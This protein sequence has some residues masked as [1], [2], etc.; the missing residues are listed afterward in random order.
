V[1]IKAASELLSWEY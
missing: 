1:V